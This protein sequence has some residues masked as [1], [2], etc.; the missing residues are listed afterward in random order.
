MD[1]ISEAQWR[2]QDAIDHA[3]AARKPP[4]AGLTHCAVLTCR[5]PITPLRQRLG[6]Q[7]CIDCQQRAEREAQQ[8]AHEG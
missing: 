5:E 8:W 2:Q 7:L 4:R 6:A 1:I 3:L